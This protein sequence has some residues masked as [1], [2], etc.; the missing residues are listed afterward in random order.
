LV[1]AGLVVLASGIGVGLGLARSGSGS[2]ATQAPISQGPIGTAPQPSSSTGTTTEGLDVQAIADAVDPA[3]VDINTTVDSFPGFAP[4]MQ[5]AGTGMVLT[6]S[7]E[8]LTNNHVIEGATSITVVIPGHSGSYTDEV[9]GADPSA[10]VALLQIEDVS[11]LPTVTLA[12]SSGLTLGEEVVAIGNALGQGG[13]PTVTAGTISALNR[14]VTVG[15]GRGGAEHLSG[16][17]QT[18]APISPGDSGGPLAD[19]SGQVVGM[20]T[21]GATGNWTQSSTDVGFAIPTNTALGIV[22]EIRAGHASS[23][24]IIGQPGFLGVQVR[25]LDSATASRLGL[26][27]TSG[28][29]VVGVIPGTPAATIGIPR[30]AVITAID[31]TTITSPD[32]LGVALHSHKAGEQVRVTWIDQKGT[33]TAT[34]RLIAGPAV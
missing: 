13:T 33:H 23:S 11:G 7:G 12:N 22:N 2:T 3:V 25:N 24:V 8:V 5:G 10:D 27:V 4:G 9:L 32:A 17:I 16:L 14:S 18:D 20:I 31:G 26:G 1:L 6:S 28:A 29:L 30:P 21:A 15:N 19:S 34:V